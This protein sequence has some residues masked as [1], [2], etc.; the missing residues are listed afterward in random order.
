VAPPAHG[1][2]SGQPQ[3]ADTESPRLSDHVDEA[4]LWQGSDQVMMP[5]PESGEATNTP[6]PVEVDVEVRARRLSAHGHHAS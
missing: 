5:M 4:S 3:G 1:G 2:S 6:F